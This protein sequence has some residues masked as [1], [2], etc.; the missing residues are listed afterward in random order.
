[1]FK[2]LKLLFKDKAEH[3]C[4]VCGEI[5]IGKDSFTSSEICTYSH[6]NDTPEQESRYPK[7]LRKE[8]KKRKD[9]GETRDQFIS[10]LLKSW[11]DKSKSSSFLDNVSKSYLP[12]GIYHALSNNDRGILSDFNFDNESHI[13]Y[14][15]LNKSL[16]L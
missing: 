10:L 1:M 12:V 13:I 4:Q 6:E 3:R 15:K 9:G 8:F 5:Y 11:E 14:E 7:T 16:I 2:F